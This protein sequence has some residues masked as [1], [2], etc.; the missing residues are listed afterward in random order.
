MPCWNVFLGC[1]P[2]TNDPNS[3][4]EQAIPL[5]LPVSLSL[6]VSAPQCTHIIYLPN[7]ATAA[8]EILITAA[9]RERGPR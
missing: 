5:S 7:A 9:R 2:G 1:K 3:A 8:A 6:S 4:M